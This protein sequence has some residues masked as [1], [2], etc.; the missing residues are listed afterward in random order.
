MSGRG[1][2][3]MTGLNQPD[4]VREERLRERLRRRPVDMKRLGLQVITCHQFGAS[5]SVGVQY[6][7]FAFRGFGETRWWML[8]VMG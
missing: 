4:V 3:M 8:M 6:R 2:V 7:P 5:S 1:D